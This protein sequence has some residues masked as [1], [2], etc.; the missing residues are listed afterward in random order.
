MSQ[1]VSN[2]KTSFCL[3]TFKR[4]DLLGEKLESC[5]VQTYK[6]YD[7]ILEYNSGIYDSELGYGYP[8]EMETKTYN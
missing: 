8:L 1:P 5:L 7:I 6:L 2:I 4:P 3:S